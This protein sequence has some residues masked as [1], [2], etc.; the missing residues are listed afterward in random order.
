MESRL[1][2]CGLKK[3]EAAAGFGKAELLSVPGNW[4]ET[5]ASQLD[6]AT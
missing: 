5:E 6:N 2:V 3:W 4:L 1:F